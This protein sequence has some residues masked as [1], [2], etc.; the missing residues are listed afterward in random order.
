M[1]RVSRLAASV[2]VAAVLFCATPARADPILITSG[3]VEA[4]FALLGAPWRAEALYLTGA[5]LSIGD[6]LEDNPAFVQLTT[7]PTIEPGAL[8]DLSGIMRVSDPV[9]AFLNDSFA[10]VAA[11]IQMTFEAS[12]VPLTCST[13]GAITECRAVALFTFAAQLTFTPLGGAPVTHHLIGRGTAEG[14]LAR[15]PSFES[16]GVRYFFEPSAVPE[17]S[18][19]TLFAAGAVVA[20]ARRWR[21]RRCAD[22]APPID[23]R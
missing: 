21:R 4:G 11:P 5:G 19:L 3:H 16:G 2:L 8:L 12:P 18:T 15:S 22:V 7:V 20:G 9:G 14:T 13:S 1:P 23:M 6:S 17:P 10:V